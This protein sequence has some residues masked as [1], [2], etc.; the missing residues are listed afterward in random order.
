VDEYMSKSRIGR[1]LF[2]E[3]GVS[4]GYLELDDDHIEEVCLGAAPDDSSDALI[5][6]AFVN[7][8]THIGDSFAYPAP[9]GTVEE[10][11]APPN[12]YK[13]RMLRLASDEKKIAGMRDAMRTMERTGTSVFADFREE[14]FEGLDHLRTASSDVS[15]TPIVLGRPVH[16]N[17]SRD[18]LAEF[19]SGCDGFGMSSIRDWPRDLLERS[20]TSARSA[21]KIFGIHASEV[22]RDNIDEVLDLRP[23]FLVHMTAASDDD[24]S[25]C[26]EAKV[27]IVVCP[28]SNHFFGIDP[29]IPRL[30]SLGAEVALGTDNGMICRPDMLEEV[31]AACALSVRDG[32]LDPALALNLA[33]LS[34]RKVLN[35]VGNITTEMGEKADLAVMEVGGDDPLNDVVSSAGSAHVIAV[36]RGGMVRRL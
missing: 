32:G 33:T 16:P 30:L 29:K 11:V 28:R 26:A 18:A 8:H 36:C 9:K 10:I 7:A 23:S 24:I 35:R 2:T 20:S 12:G 5:I 4:E 21:G 1:W 22:V 27:P 31:R 13:H 14:G 34:G 19:L 6:P 3:S 15:V 25:A 17:A